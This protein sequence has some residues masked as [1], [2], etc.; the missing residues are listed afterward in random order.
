MKAIKSLSLVLLLNIVLISSCALNKGKTQDM[1]T[2]DQKQTETKVLIKT[3]MGDMTIVLY[4]GTPY[5]SD[6]FKKLVE[7]GYFEG[8]L[9]H[10][11]IQ[12]F[13]I[14]GGDPNSKDAPAGQQLGN[15]GPGYTLPAEISPK[16]YHKKGVLSAARTGDQMNPTRRS[17]G[18]QFYIVTGK[19]Y[20]DAELN[21]LEQRMFTKFTDEQREAYK[22]VGGTPFL[23]GQYTVFGEVIE[24]IDIAEKISKVKTDQYDRPAEDVKI[25]SMK[26]VD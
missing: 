5:H 12:D 3:T 11:V 16:Y 25:I 24:G 18:S 8:L 20:T 22:T 26:I 6:N 13:M 19:V 1:N 2:Q 23:D 9:F 14:Q 17:S 15:G 21:T 7:E 10:R 4:S